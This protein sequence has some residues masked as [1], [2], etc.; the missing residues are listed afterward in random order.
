MRQPHEI[1]TQLLGAFQETL[2][3]RLGMRAA[4][5]DLFMQV[6]AAQEHRLVVEQDLI[7][8]CGDAAEADIFLQRFIAAGIAGAGIK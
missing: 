4:A 7:A 6:D 3:I 2:C 5:I 1:R 8:T